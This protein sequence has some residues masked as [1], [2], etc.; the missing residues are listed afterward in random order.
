M[1]TALKIITAIIVC[2][3]VGGISG[4]LSG[5]SGTNA[6]YQSLNKP[7]FA[8]PGWVFGAVW[9]ILYILMGTACGLVW[10]KGLSHRAV[11]LAI[12]AF[13][14]QLFLNGLWTPLFFGMHRIDLA[15]LEVILLW[16]VIAI[17]EALFWKIRP[18]AA[19]LLWPYLAWV[20]FAIALNAMFWKLN[21]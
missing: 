18:A 12:A 21:V 10:S 5:S 17:T 13:A 4:Y 20:G 14:V 19:I 16:V 2:L 3:A 8:P 11:A 9:P 15:L 7:V 1:R 6:W